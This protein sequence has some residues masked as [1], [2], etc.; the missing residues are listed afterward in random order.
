MSDQ[1]STNE[2]L[3]ENHQQNII[4]NVLGM[5]VNEENERNCEELFEQFK[6]KLYNAG[7]NIYK[8][9][10]SHKK[11]QYIKFAK[12]KLVEQGY[13]VSSIKMEI[14][15]DRITRE[16]LDI[17]RYFITVKNPKCSYSI[18]TDL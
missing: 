18:T 5:L 12:E 4:K 14:L 8:L 16:V 10:F 15:Q 11:K 9:D 2:F 1:Q 17:L 13:E 7:S 3:S 6:E